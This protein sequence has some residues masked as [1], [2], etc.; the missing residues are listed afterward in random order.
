MKD[1]MGEAPGSRRERDAAAVKLSRPGRVV[2]VLA[3]T[4]AGA[5]LTAYLV[6]PGLRSGLTGAATTDGSAAGLVT[7]SSASPISPSS[8][9]PDDAPPSPS[10]P[11]VG[12]TPAGL[13][14]ATASSATSPPTRLV[15]TRLGIDMPVQPEGV[16][17]NGQMALPSDPA[18][19]GWYQWGSGPSDAQGATVLAAHVDSKTQGVGP[20]VRLGSARAGDEVDVLVGDRRMVYRVSQVARVDKVKLDGDG[21][22]ALT[23]PAR[24]HLVTCTGAYVKGS[25]YTQNLVVVADLR[26]SSAQGS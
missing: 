1:S 15:V 5:A 23:G 10:G 12:A 25:G 3:A 20:F 13:P 26:S 4:L 17:G 24:L 16:D 19:A 21:L 7:N 9:G 2:A 6:L 22:F 8:T 18:V 11:V 14:T